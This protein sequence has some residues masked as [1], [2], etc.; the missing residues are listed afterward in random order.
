MAQE[1]LPGV[2]HVVDENASAQACIV[3]I[4]HL[5][6]ASKPAS[7]GDVVQSKRA[8]GIMVSHTADSHD[9][10]EFKFTLSGINPLVFTNWRTLLYS[11]TSSVWQLDSFVVLK[12]IVHEEEQE[13]RA[14]RVKA[15]IAMNH[16]PFFG[17]T[18]F[19]AIVTVPR[20]SAAKYPNK[21]RQADPE[22]R[23]RNDDKRVA[24]EALAKLF[25]PGGTQGPMGELKRLGNPGHREAIT[26]GVPMQS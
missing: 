25:A 23:A 3:F 21:K 20:T 5:D 15:D 8:S 12:K 16:V 14:E 1:S 10:R 11:L 22:T 4:R 24:R 17:H 6:M 18:N 26:F 7:F 13:Q 9:T 19:V 2:T